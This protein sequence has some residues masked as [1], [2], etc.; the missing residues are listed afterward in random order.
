MGAGHS[1]GVT[2]EPTRAQMTLS[3]LREALVLVLSFT[4]GAGLYLAGVQGSLRWP[5]DYAGALAAGATACLAKM[6]PTVSMRRSRD[7]G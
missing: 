2:V 7:R 3:M 6:F 4:A 1:R 5:Q